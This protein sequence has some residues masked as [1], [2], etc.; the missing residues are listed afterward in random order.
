MKEKQKEMVIEIDGQLLGKYFGRAI[1][2]MT[3]GQLD[4]LMFRI[5]ILKRRK[6]RELR[7]DKK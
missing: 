3:I 7:R 2:S 1:K 4:E 6:L 5:M